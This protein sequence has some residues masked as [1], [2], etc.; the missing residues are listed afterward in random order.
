MKIKVKPQTN[1]FQLLI[2]T[3][4]EFAKFAKIELTGSVIPFITAIMSLL[5]ANVN[6]RVLPW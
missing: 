6:I 2:L 5:A 1:F 4:F 3:S